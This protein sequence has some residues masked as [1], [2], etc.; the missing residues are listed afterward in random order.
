MLDWPLGVT[1]VSKAASERDRVEALH[2]E[3]QA[4][5]KKRSLTSVTRDYFQSVAQLSTKFHIGLLNNG[6]NVSNA[7]GWNVMVSAFLSAAI[8]AS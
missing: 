1:F 5:E 4:L 7:T 2:C 3:R 6:P 8:S